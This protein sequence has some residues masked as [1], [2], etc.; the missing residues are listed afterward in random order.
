[1][2]FSKD[3]SAALCYISHNEDQYILDVSKKMNKKFIIALAVF[4]FISVGCGKADPVC[5]LP[6]GTPQ[7]LSVPPDQLPTPTPAN[8]P[9]QVKIGSQEIV[10]DKLVDGPLCNDQWSGVIYV[11]CD[12]E[13]YPWVE[14]PIFLKQCQLTIEPQTVVYVADHN[15]TAYYNGCSCHTGVTPEP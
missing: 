2:P 3:L 5:P 14:E 7:F 8:G 1:L 4:I 15:N 12:V 11:G 6:T 10:A 9:Y 13:V